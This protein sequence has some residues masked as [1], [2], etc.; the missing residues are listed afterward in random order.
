MFLHVSVILFTGA[1]IPACLAGG[2]P[3][4]LAGLGGVVSQHALQVV[5][6][7]ALQVSGGVSRPTPRGR[8]R[9][10]VR[11]VSRPTPWEGL[12]A[13][14]QGV[15]AGCIPACTEADTPHPRRSMLGDTANK[16]AVRILLECILVHRNFHQ[17]YTSLYQICLAMETLTVWNWRTI[18][19]PS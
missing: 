4:Y 17:T 12:L 13:H 10:L 8:L 18:F 2:I 1:G 7:H 3:A 14:T 15:G 11:G 19:I 9:G 6:Q 5:S 16:R